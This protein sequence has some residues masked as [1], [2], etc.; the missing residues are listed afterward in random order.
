MTDWDDC[1]INDKKDALA[2]RSSFLIKR[3]FLRNK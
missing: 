2:K 3:I 1:V